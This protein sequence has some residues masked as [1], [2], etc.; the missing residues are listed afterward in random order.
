MA[1]GVW[2]YGRGVSPAGGMKAPI[3]PKENLTCLVDSSSDLKGPC[4]RTLDH[5]FILSLLSDL[6]LFFVT[7]YLLPDW[8]PLRYFPSF[9]SF[10]YN[11]FSSFL[12]DIFLS[13]TK[14]L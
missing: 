5:F 1:A 4:S 7:A 14:T 12:V 10:A 3:V 11:H 13:R 8:D 6:G 9:T 2:A